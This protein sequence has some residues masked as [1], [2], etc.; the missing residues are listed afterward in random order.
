MAA[1][2][3]VAIAVLTL[4]L[5][6][7]R[8]RG[9]NEGLAS[10]LGAVLVLLL[11]LVPIG[12]AIRLELATWNVFLFFLGMMAVAALADQ[13]GVFDRVAFEAARLARGRVAVLYL[14]VFLLGAVISILFANDSAALVL[15]PIV[16]GLVVRLTLDPLPFVFATT[17]IADTASIILPVSNPLNVIV[18]DSFH[19][20][21]ASYVSHLWLSALL[22]ILINLAVFFLLFRTSLQRRC[23]R[24][25]QP[26]SPVGLTSTLV[27]LALL[28]IAYLVA[29]ADRFPLGVVSLFGA[30]IMAMNL[31][32]LRSLRIA[33]L[34]R[35]ISW[36]IFAFIAGMLVVVQSL[37]DSGV[38][39]ALGR[40]LVHTASGSHLAAIAVTTI[41]T[42]IG[43]N[44][45]NNLPM[46][47]V[48]VS[49]IHPLHLAPGIRLDLIYGTIMGC[50]LGPNLTHLGSLA[51]FLWLFFL[52]RQGL[53]V[54]TWDYF[55]IGIV[56]TP[57]MVLG[58]IV[59]LWLTS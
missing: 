12:Q 22:V 54:S 39:S 46:A 18:A 28:A 55:R 10:L 17:F 51:T 5:I 45:I 26:P 48:T 9:L 21:L 20:D 43:S 49:T 15:T 38:T 58:A 34:G 8:P 57:L 16:Y 13:S 14:A 53:D 25:A 41:G 33:R 4:C 44:L 1:A 29:S 56:V 37:H 35:D 7:I 30:V 52:R 3:A 59:G 32:R 27:L 2:E 36:P 11:G 47:L 19:L 42:A 24:I 40:G 31:L 23:S 50:D 6:V